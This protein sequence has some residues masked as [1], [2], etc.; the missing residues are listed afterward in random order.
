M[1]FTSHTSK[2]LGET[3]SQGHCYYRR[4]VLQLGKHFSDRGLDQQ[5]GVRISG[6]GGLVDHHQFV[7]LEIID[8]AGGGVYGQGGAADDQYLGFPNETHCGVYG[9]LIKTFLIQHHVGLYGAAAGLA[10]GDVL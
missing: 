4:L 2:S 3:A 7:P 6:G 9:F 10:F 1:C 5:I 8:Q